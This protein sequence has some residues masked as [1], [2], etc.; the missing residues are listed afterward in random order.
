LGVDSA[1]GASD[2]AILAFLERFI[3]ERLRASE[4]HPD[5]WEPL[6]IRDP[7]QTAAVL[8]KNPGDKYS[9]REM[10]QFTKLI[11][12]TL[13]GVTVALDK[14]PIVTKVSRSGVLDEAIWLEYSQERLASYGGDVSKLPDILKARN[15]SVPGGV[16]E[17]EGKE[18]TVERLARGGIFC[19]RRPAH[20]QKS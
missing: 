16:L 18:V 10:E 4:V 15:I 19:R 6:L 13:L 8:A 1:T 20:P 2:A 7:G 5:V 11:E 14:T 9:Y 12:R 3:R 17:V